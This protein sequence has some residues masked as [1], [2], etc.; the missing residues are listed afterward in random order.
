DGNG[1]T[2]YGLYLNGGSGTGFFSSVAGGTIK[3]VTFKGEYSSADGPYAL[4]TV[5]GDETG[6][7]RL[8]MKFEEESRFGDLIDADVMN[9]DFEEVSRLALGGKVRTCLVCGGADARICAKSGAHTREETI[10]AISELLRKR[11]HKGE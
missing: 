7:K 9:R 3:D 4:Y 11:L 2:I 10:I 1:K 5:S 6:I 8:L